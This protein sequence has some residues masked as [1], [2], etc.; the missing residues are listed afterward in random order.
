M[1]K[2]SGLLELN[3]GPLESGLL[4]RLVP[5]R[6]RLG[7]KA[8]HDAK[9]DRNRRV[10]SGDRPGR[11]FFHGCTQRDLDDLAA[12]VEHPDG[13]RCGGLPIGVQGGC[14]QA[15]GIKDPV[16]SVSGGSF[17]GT[18]ASSSQ[19][20]SG[21]GKGPKGFDVILVSLVDESDGRVA[22]GAVPPELLGGLPPGPRSLSLSRLSL[23]MPKFP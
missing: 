17:G 1:E 20:L 18:T 16:G 13:D 2:V 23:L 14:R 5:I 22:A 6:Q 11:Q 8:R 4:H 21:T 7:R 19:T 15:R 3:S 10:G 12:P 9:G